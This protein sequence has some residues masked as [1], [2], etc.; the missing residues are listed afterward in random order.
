[1]ES[2][3]DV[4]DTVLIVGQGVQDGILVNVLVIALVR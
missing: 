3:S 2:G 1:M 4:D